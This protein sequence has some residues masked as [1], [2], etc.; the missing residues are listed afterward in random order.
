M[1]ASDSTQDQMVEVANA[2]GRLVSVCHWSLISDADIVKG[3]EK[4]N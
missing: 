2:R 1:W 4:L 3:V